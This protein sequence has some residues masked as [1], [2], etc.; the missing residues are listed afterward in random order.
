MALRGVFD[1]NFHSDVGEPFPLEFEIPFVIGEK[2]ETSLKC[3]PNCTNA[4]LGV[5]YTLTNKRA[6][7]VEFLYGE[8]RANM[9]ILFGSTGSVE[10]I[11]T[12]GDWIVCETKF[13]PGSFLSGHFIDLS[14][15]LTDLN[16]VEL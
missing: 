7:F 12:A 8:K 1:V 10:A 3:R 9:T 16:V 14:V 2:I 15:C 5:H 4:S 6:L 13:F 11:K